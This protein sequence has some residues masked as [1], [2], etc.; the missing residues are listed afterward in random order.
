MGDLSTPVGGILGLDKS[1]INIKICILEP[2]YRPPPWRAAWLWVFGWNISS[3]T[4]SPLLRDLS[5]F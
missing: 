4:S 2:G 3:V 5:S 1:F